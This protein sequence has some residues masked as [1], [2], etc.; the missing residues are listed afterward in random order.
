MSR[1]ALLL[2]AGLGGEGEVFGVAGF[3]GDEVGV[4]G[5]VEAGGRD[6][7]AELQCCEGWK[8]IE[9]GVGGKKR[10]KR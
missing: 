5:E 6:E 10:R 3:E 4:E 2:D 7:E 1:S 9:G 8:V